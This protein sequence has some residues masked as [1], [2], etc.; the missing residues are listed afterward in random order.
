MQA[1]SQLG[2]NS[3]EF[4]G[5]NSIIIG[6]IQCDKEN[7]SLQHHL[8]IIKS[9]KPIFSRVKFNFHHHE[10]NV[11]VDILARKAVSCNSACVLY[12]TYPFLMSI[13]T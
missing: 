2:Y 8:Y 6:I 13:V 12:N 7:L 1:A 11:C 5:Y 4:E 3:I 10:S 9:C